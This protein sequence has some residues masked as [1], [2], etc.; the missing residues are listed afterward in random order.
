MKRNLP[1]DTQLLGC[2][3]E[4]LKIKK[5]LVEQMDQKYAESMEKLPVNM[6]KL[7]ESIADGFALL[8]QVMM[9]QQ[10]SPG[11]Y[12]PQPAFNPYMQSSYNSRMPSYPSIIVA[13]PHHLPILKLMMIIRVLIFFVLFFTLT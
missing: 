6:E 11:M 1:V 8:K 5:R 4:E 3:Q 10:P 7:T 2:A 13:P 12:H 9:Y